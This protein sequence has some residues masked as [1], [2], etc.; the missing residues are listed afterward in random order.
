MDNKPIPWLK[1]TELDHTNAAELAARIA[2]AEETGID[3]TPRGYAGYPTWDLPSCKSRW[4]PAFDVVL[5]RRRCYRKLDSRLPSQEVLGRVLQFSHG[6]A[7]DLY[8]GPT[9]SA[10][11]LQSLELYLVHWQSGW[12]PPGVYHYDRRGHFL[13]QVVA[14]A[15]AEYW[16]RRVPS[17]QQIE[18]GAIVWLLVGDSA[19]ESAKYD[20]RAERFLLLEAGHLMQNL[21]L[22]SESVGYCTAPLGGC[23]EGEVA[24]TLQL[25][26]TDRVLYAGVF[27]RPL[28]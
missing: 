27:G 26:S 20:L 12:L 19:R 25:L 18:G 21:C 3:N 14:S 17:L 4:R 28:A 2:F 15:D 23:L 7:D 8:R 22:V 10:G 13:S 5:Q 11:G 16:L 6:I 24:R 9:P 1:P